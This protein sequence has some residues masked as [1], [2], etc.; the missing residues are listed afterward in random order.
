MLELNTIADFQQLP[1]DL[2]AN[3]QKALR[4][5]DRLEDYLRG[6]NKKPGDTTKPSH[7][8]KW[9]PC[10]HCV[11]NSPGTCKHC[12]K[13]GHPGWVWHEASRN[14]AD[15]H[16][17]QIHKCLKALYYA[18]AGYSQ[19]AEEFVDARLRMIFDIG[20]AWHD[21]V[22]RYGRDGAWCKPEH[23]KTEP[24][25]DPDAVGPDGQPI[26]P[27]AAYYRVRGHADAII[28]RYECQNVPG[29]GDISVRVVHEYKT[30]NSGQYEKLTRPKPEHKWQANI[31]AAAFNIPV[32]V[33]LYTNKD[34][35]YTTDF[36]LP[37]D[38]AIWNEIA[39]KMERVKYFADAKQDPPWEETSAINNRRECEDCGYRKICGP[40]QAQLVQI[41][42]TGT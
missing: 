24:E 4:T 8:A 1:F 12:A 6:L 39:Q 7:Q 32:V 13:H 36:P 2:Q 42:G 30:M 35:C 25:I 5:K 17:S 41:K 14:D 34:N 15:I 9:E 27:L 3:V 16:P 29:L 10:R 38:T 23:Y 11:P 37:F 19:H 20:S 40:T 22:Q 26:L 33:Y 18:V 28:D 21:T 31:Y